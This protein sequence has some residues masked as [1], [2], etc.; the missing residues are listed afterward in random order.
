MTT[1][2]QVKGYSD[3]VGP[4]RPLR[5]GGNSGDA[6][7]PYGELVA[8]AKER[9]LNAEAPDVLIIGMLDAAREPY[10]VHDLYLIEQLTTISYRWRTQRP[11]DSRTAATSRH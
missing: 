9:G 4:R 3:R 2:A 10:L 1:I 8:A 11:H 7:P 5:V 6:I